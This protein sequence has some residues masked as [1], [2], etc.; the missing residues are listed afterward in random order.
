MSLK[1][2][3][4][5]IDYIIYADGHLPDI[6]A[7]INSNFGLKSFIINDHCICLNIKKDIVNKVYPFFFETKYL[8]DTNGPMISVY[9]KLHASEQAFVNSMCSR[10]CNITIANVLNV[11]QDP[12]DHGWFKIRVPHMSY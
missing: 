4:F 12:L 3:D 2:Y 11:V 7:Y 9:E 5:E 6:V 10:L 8:P 1:R